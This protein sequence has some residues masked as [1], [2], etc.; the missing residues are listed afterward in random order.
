MGAGHQELGA[1]RLSEVAR[2]RGWS[3]AQQYNARRLIDG[4]MG[5]RLGYKSFEETT[6]GEGADAM[7]GEAWVYY[8]YED[9][10]DE[11]AELI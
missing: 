11:V 5:E 9:R 10:L 4:G 1:V 6:V 8:L 2:A 7:E 3:E